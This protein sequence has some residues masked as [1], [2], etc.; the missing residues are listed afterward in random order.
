MRS[1]MI[2]ENVE[3]LEVDLM[4]EQQGR[5]GFR[6]GAVWILYDFANSVLMITFFMDLAVACSRAGS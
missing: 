5:G 6:N 1:R 4:T 3:H 2:H